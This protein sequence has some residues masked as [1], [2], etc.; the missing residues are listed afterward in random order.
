MCSCGEDTCVCLYP[1]EDDDGYE[2][3][4]ICGDGHLPGEVPFT[5]ETGD[6]I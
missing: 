4:G 5:C 3:C 1:D 6:G 2:L